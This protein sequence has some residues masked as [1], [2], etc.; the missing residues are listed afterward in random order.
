MPKNNK[1]LI[2]MQ[3]TLP[4]Q[5][6]FFL[7]KNWLDLKTKRQKIWDSI[8]EQRKEMYNATIEINRIEVDISKAIQ[9][10]QKNEQ[11]VI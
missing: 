6:L 9:K 2:V 5:N 11:K 4:Y 3:E 7:N 1:K 10:L 8:R